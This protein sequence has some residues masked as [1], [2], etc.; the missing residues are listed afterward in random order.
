MREAYNGQEI[1]ALIKEKSDVNIEIIDG[2]AA[3]IASAIYFT[4]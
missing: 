1:V 2:K 4:Y 3:I